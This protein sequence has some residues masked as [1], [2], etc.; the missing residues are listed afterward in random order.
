[1]SLVQWRVQSMQNK[2]KTTNYKEEDWGKKENRLLLF[3]KT[4]RFIHACMISMF[5]I[6]NKEFNAFNINIA[7]KITV[8]PLVFSW[9]IEIL[10]YYDDDNPILMAFFCW[11]TITIKYKTKTTPIWLVHSTY[12][13]IYTVF[14]L[15]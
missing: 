3:W 6:N 7:I 1:M 12:N 9:N 13:S 8:S 10:V 11:K 4:V 5:W 14:D 2:T 15:L